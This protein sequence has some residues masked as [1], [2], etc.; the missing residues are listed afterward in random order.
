MFKN[1]IISAPFGNWLNF[2][3]A[4]STL[5]SFTWQYRGGLLYRLW[6]MARTLRYNWRSKSW[7]NKLGL[8]NPGLNSLPAT[9]DNRYDDKIISIYGFNKEE[10]VNL[11]WAIAHRYHPLAVELNLSCPNVNHDAF[12]ADVIP[13]VD[14][15]MGGNVQIIAKL[16]PIKWLNLAKP[17]YDYGVRIFHCC[18]T[19]PTPGGGLSGKPLKQY[20]LWATEELR[21]KW[22]DSVRI[23]GGGGVT[24]HEDVLDYRMAGADHVA[25]G[26]MLLNPL[27]LAR[28]TYFLEDVEVSMRYKIQTS[29]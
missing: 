24:S 7:V 29:E 15:L 11:A 17:L 8:P 3:G 13:G 6:R 27:R 26:S 12:I 10:W 14:I 28:F 1:I 21:Q 5:G 23:I 2:P 22:G 25:V 18:N 4:T 16:P 20:S 19:I 9:I